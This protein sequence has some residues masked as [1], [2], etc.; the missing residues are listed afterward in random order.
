M[1][2]SGTVACRNIAALKIMMVQLASKRLKPAIDSVVKY[3]S[4]SNLLYGACSIGPF[5]LQCFG[6]LKMPIQIELKYSID[7]T[8]YLESDF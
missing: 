8:F 7:S 6:K 1:Q 5:Y 4:V 3:I 2:D